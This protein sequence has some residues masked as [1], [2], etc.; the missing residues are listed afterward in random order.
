[1]ASSNLGRVQGGGFFGSSS[2]ST[3]SILK[4]EVQTNGSISPLV[5]DT[6]VN[7]NGDLCKITAI[8]STAYT[9]T[10]YGSI[11]GATGAQG[12]QGPAGAT[13][14]AGPA[15]K[16]GAKGETGPK[17]EKGDK[18]EKG[19][20]GYGYDPNK[21]Y[22]FGVDNVGAA[23]LSALVRTDDAKSLSVYIDGSEIQSDFDSCYPWSEMKEVTD[24]NGNVFIK[25]PKFYS[26][27]TKN[28]NGT[29]KHQISGT[30]HSGFTTLFVDWV[31]NEIDYVLVGKY[32]GSGTSSLVESK[33]EKTVLVNVTIDAFRKGCVANGAGYQQ[34]DYL[35]YLILQ[36]L[37]L[38]EFAT[39]DSQSIMKGYTA[40][41]NSAAIATGRTD[42]VATP[43]GSEV[44]NTSGT[45]AM[46]YRGI[47]NL[48]GNVFKWI[49]GISFHNDSVYVCYDPTAYNGGKI[50]AP[51]VYQG[52]R[53][54]ASGY[55]KSFGPLSNDPLIQ[56][57]TSTS[58]GSDA[59][60][61][62]DYSSYSTSGTVVR[63]GG[64]WSSGSS[65][66][67]WCLFG[68]NAASTSYANI[69]GRLCYKPL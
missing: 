15:G 16:D 30:K 40:S 57:I 52:K 45:S 20:D 50:D 18:G 42:T 34:F 68:H 14:P 64:D 1:M 3:T 25:I 17:G 58:G 44:S 47:E 67:L 28:S 38:I 32:E 11:K 12:S 43:S 61:F 39:T 65:A 6:I 51:Y 4:T 62:A 5:G 48:Y 69:G 59:T 21:A 19:N 27:I 2:T 7:K 54:T 53:A 63:F 37:F 24:K 26:K 10:K 23:S 41:S 46:K 31:G 35:I 8:T 55:V 33:A 66:G 9:V 22:I 49:D 29:Y 36:E 56:Y 13:G 60:Y